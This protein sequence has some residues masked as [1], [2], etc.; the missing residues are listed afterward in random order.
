MSQAFKS[1]DYYCYH[2]GNSFYTEQEA[3]NCKAEC[4]PP[5]DYI[6]PGQDTLMYV[7][8]YEVSRHYGGPEEGGWYYNAGNLLASIPVSAI[9]VAGH[10]SCWSCEMA[11]KGIL[12]KETGEPYVHCKWAFHLEPHEDKIEFFMAYLKEMY[13]E[14]ERGNIY[15]VLGGTRVDINVEDNPGK[16]FPEHRPHYE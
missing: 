1:Y 2:C 9:S 5:E 13:G 10:E 15:S 11:D 16:N 14:L 12:H 6:K 3:V 8:A 7:N 4:E